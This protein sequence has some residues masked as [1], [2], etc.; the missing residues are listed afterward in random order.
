MISFAVSLYLSAKRVY[1]LIYICC[2]M[3]KSAEIDQ[4]K[5][6]VEVAHSEKRASEEVCLYSISLI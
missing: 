6:A 3:E 1:V 2:S 5:H 4:L